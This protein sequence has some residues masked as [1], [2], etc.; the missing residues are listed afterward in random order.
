MPRTCRRYE[1]DTIYHVTTRGV[2]RQSIFGS[3]D[4]RRYFVSTLLEALRK[5]DAGLFAYCLMNNHAHLLLACRNTPIGVPLHHAFTAYAM[6]FNSM[7]GRTGHLFQGRYHSRP[8][9]DL[10]HLHSAVAY[11]HANPLRAGLVGRVTDWAWSTHSDWNFGLGGRLDLLRLSRLTGVSMSALRD[12]YVRRI[13]LLEAPRPRGLTVRALIDETA[14]MLCL[15]AEDLASGRKGDLYTRAKLM[16]LDGARREG[17][18]ISR[19][20]AALACTP[21]ALIRMRNRERARN[22]MRLGSRP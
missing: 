10:T 1:P 20:A 6:R 4:D 7:N 22:R 9:R 19:L 3:D 8:V 18:P 21:N 14:G 11:I 5:F 2:N 17:H 15:N 12:E 13:E 16:L